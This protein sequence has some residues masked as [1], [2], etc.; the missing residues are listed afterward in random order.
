MRFL[1]ASGIGEDGR[2][3]DGVG[4]DYS[5]GHEDG[6]DYEGDLDNLLEQFPALN[7]CEALLLEQAATI[8]L[9]MMVMV[10]CMFLGHNYLKI[11]VSSDANEIRIPVAEIQREVV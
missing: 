6:Q 5:D 3:S 1:A 9:V 11:L 8:F 2:L 10:M 7:S 4:Q